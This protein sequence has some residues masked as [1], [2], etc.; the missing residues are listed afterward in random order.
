LNKSEEKLVATEHQ[1]QTTE[2]KE[3]WKERSK[4]QV[5][6]AYFA[7]M[8]ALTRQTHSFIYPF[9]VINFARVTL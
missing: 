3:C 4:D 2:E 7:I 5:Y 6:S 8:A 9:T 1:M